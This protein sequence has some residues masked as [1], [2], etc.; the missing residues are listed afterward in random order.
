MGGMAE[1]DLLDTWRRR[2]P[3]MVARLER[4]KILQEMAHVLWNLKADA[5]HAYRKA[6]MGP[7]DAR[8]QA[9]REWLLN[10]PETEDSP[11][12]DPPDQITTLPTP[13]N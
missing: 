6:G 10:E 1:Q 7:T 9:E 13:S 11:E 8:E 5:A 4:L 12:V 3:K 2:R